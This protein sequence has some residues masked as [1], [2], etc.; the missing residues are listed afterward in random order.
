MDLYAKRSRRRVC[1]RETFRNA[2][3]CLGDGIFTLESMSCSMPRSV[4]ENSARIFSTVRSSLAAESSVSSCERIAALRS[5]M[6]SVR[7]SD[8]EVASA[9]SMDSLA[10]EKSRT[11]ICGF[12]RGVLSRE[13]TRAG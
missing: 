2:C 9:G 10:S 7:T 5:A 6:S 12:D 4:L 13:L 1:N 11:L 8:H 3:C